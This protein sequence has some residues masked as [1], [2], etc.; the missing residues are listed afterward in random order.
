VCPLP[1]PKRDKRSAP[2][3][4]MGPRRFDGNPAAVLVYPSDR[5]GA[6]RVVETTLSY[7]QSTFSPRVIHIQSTYVS[8][9]VDPRGPHGVQRRRG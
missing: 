3:G 8:M 1:T 5:N 7:T 9:Y 4:Q 6:V 2:T